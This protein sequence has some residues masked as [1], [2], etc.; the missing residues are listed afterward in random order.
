[1]PIL[2]TSSRRKG[3]G[4]FPDSRHLRLSKFFTFTKASIILRLEKSEN[5]LITKS[6]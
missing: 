5:V 6:A 1:M 4:L 2:N 3:R